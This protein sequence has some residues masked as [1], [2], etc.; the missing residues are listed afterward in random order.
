MAHFINPEQL[1]LPLEPSAI[2]SITTQERR[3]IVTTLALLL[4]G[5]VGASLDE[6]TT[7]ER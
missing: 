3:R 1:P 2:D 6:A 7:D 4:L 5:A